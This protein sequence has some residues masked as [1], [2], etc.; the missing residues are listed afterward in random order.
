MIAEIADERTG[1]TE[2]EKKPKNVNLLDGGPLK[3]TKTYKP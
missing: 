3:S 1:F 2:K